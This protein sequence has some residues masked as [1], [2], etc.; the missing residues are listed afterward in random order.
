MH[1]INYLLSE[2]ACK[3]YMYLSNWKMGDENPPQPI[4]IRL[5]ANQTSAHLGTVESGCAIRRIFNLPR[6]V[7]DTY[8][9]IIVSLRGPTNKHLE[10]H[11]ASRDD[12]GGR[13]GPVPGTPQH[14]DLLPW[15]H[16]V[17][18]GDE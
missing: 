4:A 8:I 1:P 18:G 10:T 5:S 2:P 9:I 12:G 11:E 13:S 16:V 15:Q 3:K 6:L 17:V 7:S 14:G